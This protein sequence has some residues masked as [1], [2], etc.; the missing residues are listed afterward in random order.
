MNRAIKLLVL[1]SLV[2]INFFH[3][4]GQ[5]LSLNQREMEDY[6]RREQLL[7]KTDSTISFM[8]RPLYPQQSLKKDN[9]I[10]LDGTFTDEDLSKIKFRF[11][12]NKGRFQILPVMWRTQ[13]NSN[14]AFGLNDGSMI[15]NRGLQ[16]LISMGFY[17]EYGPFSIQLQPEFIHAAN[18]DFQGFPTEHYG[19]TWMRYYEWLNTSDIPERFGTSPYTRILPGQSSIRFNHRELSIGISTE[20]L[21][22]GPARR[23]SLLMS[24]HAP[25]FL[26]A[27]INTREPINTPIGKFETQ[28]IAGRL[29]D[30][31]IAPPQTDISYAQTPLYVAKQESQNWRYISGFVLSYQPTWVPGL[32]LGFSSVSQMYNSDMSKFGDYLPLFNSQKGPESISRPDVDKRNQLSAGYFRWI[33]PKGRFEFYGE[34]GSN[35]NS[36][37]LH[38]FL[39]N[40]DL[41]R[42]FSF[43]LTH[44]I[45]LKK[46]DAFMQVGLEITQTGQT[47][48]ENILAKNSWYTHPHVRH[49]YTHQGQVLGFGYGPGSNVISAELAWV[50]NFNKIGFQLEYINNNNDF[51]YFAFEE[52]KDW[53]TKYVDIIPGFI[54]EW[55]VSN[56]LLS[57]TAQFQRTLNYKW[58]L[59][60]TGDQYFVPGLDKNNTI[61]R[62]SATYIFK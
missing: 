35:G 21:W 24:N 45:P 10:D 44:L 48:R 5:S 25:G 27:T 58:Y 8:I 30:S 42:A 46:T 36:R 57:A 31:G 40:P 13:Y 12:E 4:I 1:S 55:R 49:G 15:P 11:L 62:L 56:L 2:A 20:N 59:R 41:N 18:R 19:I 39:I 7:G 14:Y 16:H 47:I 3:A 43:G 37:S 34:Y 26:H 22:W 33:S 38:D 61:G 9:G 53:R 52:S 51:Y 28:L 17:G 60:Q 54:T 23:S 6:L 29:E 32:F 50:R